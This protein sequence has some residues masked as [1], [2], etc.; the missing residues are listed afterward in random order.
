MPVATIAGYLGVNVLKS[1]R[2]GSG[3]TSAKFFGPKCLTLCEQQYF[4]LVRRF[5][6]HKIT[7]YAKIM[8]HRPL[9]S[10]ATL[11]R[12]GEKCYACE[13]QEENKVTCG[14]V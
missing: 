5:S 7:R 11:M 3:V 13:G 1:V 10:L 2:T 6:K 14:S 4:C 12:T 9:N 8:G